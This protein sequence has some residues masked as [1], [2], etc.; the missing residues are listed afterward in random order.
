M[1]LEAWL[2]CREVVRLRIYCHCT[3]VTMQSWWADPGLHVLQLQSD[4]RQFGGHTLATVMSPWAAPVRLNEP[5]L[6]TDPTS[7]ANYWLD[8]SSIRTIE[9]SWALLALDLT[10]KRLEGSRLARR[11]NTHSNTLAEMSSWARKDSESVL[12]VI[13]VLAIMPHWTH[14]HEAQSQEVP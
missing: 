2:R 5:D 13:C 6:V 4:T 9:T 7:S 12:A 3:L 11:W 8:L 14:A 1:P 10:A